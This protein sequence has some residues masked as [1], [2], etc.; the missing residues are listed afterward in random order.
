MG[1]ISKSFSLLLIIVLAVSSLT[2]IF[3]SIP[4]GTAQSGTNVSYIIGSDTTWTQANS[5]Y[6]FTGNVL[7][8][9]GVTLTIE[10]GATVNL[11]SYYLEVNGSLMI[12]QGVTINMGTSYAYIQVNGILDAIGTSTNPI[13]INGAL[14]FLTNFGPTTYPSI[15][16]AQ[17]S[18]ESI[19]ENSIINLTDIIAHNSVKFSG[20]TMGTGGGMIFYGGSPVITNN[21]I[22]SEVDFSGGSP[23]FS[24]NRIEQGFIVLNEYG[25]NGINATITD[26]VISDAKTGA[27]AGIELGAL[28]APGN[29][30]T[31]TNGQVI[32][33]RNLITN[34][35]DGIDIGI[36]NIPSGSIIQDNTIVNNSVGISVTNLYTPTITGN[37][38]YNNSYNMQLSG[39][40][41]DNIDATYN[42]WGT[43]DQQA[44]NQTI[45]DFK[46]DFN[47]G[48]VNFVPFLTAPN[49]EALPNPN[50]QITTPSTSPSPTAT[51]N[52]TPTSTTI[53]QSTPSP[54]PTLTSV[55]S[56][57]YA[58][59]LLITTITV[60]IIALLLAVIIFLLLYMRRRRI[61][62]SQT[63][64][65]PT[66]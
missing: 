5:P 23:T 52:S 33:E 38:I 44:I 19:I 25:N 45:Y 14:G 18:K 61:A 42:W 60:V 53:T 9:N 26:N 1:T 32:I 31:G 15:T 28:G 36:P 51:P 3:A 35:F 64:V 16:F 17:T 29:V 57:S 50:A 24:N 4:F 13:Y 40:A 49:P 62:F 39:Q 59:L 48:T 6:N 37:N 12:Q 65:T 22:A 47:L 20:N 7:V 8:N 46:D 41:S 54:T 27:L 66:P 63:K 10:S 21:D 34:S 56:A 2:L 58:S 11:N 30:I 55:G 43:T